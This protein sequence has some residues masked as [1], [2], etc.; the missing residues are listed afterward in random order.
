MAEEFMEY[1][2]FTT[3]DKEGKELEMA[4][5]DEF[6]YEHKNYIVA[7]LIENDTINED[8]MFIFLGKVIDGELTVEK[9]AEAKEYEKIATAYLDIES[10]KD[11]L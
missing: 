6:E 11:M 9:I 8:G 1:V 7:S 10:K 2:T 5:V 3:T 4:V